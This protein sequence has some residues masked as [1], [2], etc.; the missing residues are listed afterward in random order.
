MDFYGKVEHFLTW[1][2]I[3]KEERKIFYLIKGISNTLCSLRYSSFKCL[4]GLLS[5]CWIT[6]T[7][8]I[9]LPI[10]GLLP[11]AG[12]EP[13]TFQDSASKVAGL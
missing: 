11:S 7:H 13:I 2:R 8:T 12:T 5:L 4:V 6:V 1:R 3:I 10:E 9:R